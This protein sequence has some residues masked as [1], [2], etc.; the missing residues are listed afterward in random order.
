MGTTLLLTVDCA[1]A[2]HPNNNTTD[3]NENTVERRIDH[4]TSGGVTF[5]QPHCICSASGFF[6]YHRSSRKGKRAC[7]FSGVVAGRKIFRTRRIVHTSIVTR[8]RAMAD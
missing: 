4:P 6:L 2:A 5:D 1:P 3:R 8:V 7:R